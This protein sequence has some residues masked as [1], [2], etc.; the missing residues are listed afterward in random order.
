M[1]QMA[2]CRLSQQL[3]VE[4]RLAAAR[5][6]P[7]ASIVARQ[8]AGMAGPELGAGDVRAVRAA[9]DNEPIVAA[10]AAPGADHPRP[11]RQ[12]AQMIA[13]GKGGPAVAAPA[14]PAVQFRRI[15]RMEAHRS[16]AGDLRPSPAA[17]DGIAI[18]MARRGAGH[19]HDRRGEQDHHAGRDGCSASQRS[20]LVPRDAAPTRRFHAGNALHRR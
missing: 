13:R 16:P 9:F 11:R 4:K 17:G 6:P 18:V 8:I 7:P 20:S 19:R 10:R 2:L 3:D 14:V 5:E 15:H 12:A 1:G